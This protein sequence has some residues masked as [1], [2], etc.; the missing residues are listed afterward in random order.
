MTPDGVLT[1]AVFEIGPTAPGSTV[2]LIEKVAIAPVARSIVV[3]MLLPEPPE[4]PHAPDPATAHVHETAVTCEGTVSA[5]VAP[6]TP[7][8]PLFV[9]VTV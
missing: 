8:G 3:E 4:L 6:I 7:V 9:T 1:D 2:P 5:N